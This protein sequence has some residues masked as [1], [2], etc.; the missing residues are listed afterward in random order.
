[1]GQARSRRAVRRAI[2]FAALSSLIGAGAFAFL[3]APAAAQT[4]S[5]LGYDRLVAFGDSL[6]DNGNLWIATGGAQP[7]YPSR[8]FSN[9][10]VWAETLAGPMAGFFPMAPINNASSTNFAFGGARADAA[11]ANPPGVPQQIGAYAMRGGAFGPS[12]LASVW[13]GANDLFQTLPL[14]AANPATAQA[15]MGAAAATAARNVAGATSQLAGMGARSILVLNLPDIGA[16]PAFNTGPAASLASYSALTFNTALA[17]DLAAVAAARPGANIVQVD[18]AGLFQA[19]IANPGAFGFSNVTQGCVFVAACLAAPAAQQNAYLFWDTVHPTA[20]GHA[21]IAATVAQ[22][23]GAP[24]LALAA[25]SISDTALTTRR[26]DAMRGLDRLGEHASAPGRNEF[27]VSPYGDIGRSR[28]G[29]TRYG[30]EWRLGGVQFGMTRALSTELLFG[31]VGSVSL[32]EVEG[33]NGS[34]ARFD[35]A[36]FGV[37]VL[38]AWRRGDV[39]VRGGVGAG[40][41][42]VSD[43]RRKT[44]GPLENKADGSVWSASALLE[45]GY[46]LRM[47]AMTLTPSARLGWLHATSASFAETGVVAPID[48]RSRSVDA[49]MGGVELRAAYEL[50]ATQPGRRMSAFALIGYE[51]F[52]SVSGDAVRG[53]LVANTALPFATAVGDLRGE[54][55]ILGAGLSGEIGAMKLGADYRVSFGRGS[56]GSD[57]MRHRFGLVGRM[58]F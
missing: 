22:Y 49:I 9:G 23:L 42:A 36:N 51:D 35:V 17:S 57:D 46:D 26:S 25:A 33:R 37:D 38:G 15:T 1:M 2:C 18:I 29:A 8:R 21:L 11:V 5:G 53:R 34:P 47:G 39:F 12:N 28:S 7:P 40:V 27:F 55:L 24:I 45:A 52:L 41:G 50:L 4:L 19:A 32:G 58:A 43:W 48:Y 31:L 3:S 13:A 16:A 20:A 44:V 14:A 6:T 54:G 30:Q 10:P 56:S